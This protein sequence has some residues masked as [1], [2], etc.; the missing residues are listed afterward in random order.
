MTE[1]QVLEDVCRRLEQAGIAY[2]L[3]GSMAMSYYA[4]PRMTR[5]IDLVVAVEPDQA[6]KLASAFEPDYYVPREQLEESIRAHGMFNL[7]HLESVVKVDLIVR[8]DEP[9][10]RTEFDRRRRV[11]LPGFEAWIASKEDLVL[12]KLVWAREGES[13]V[14]RRDVRNLLDSGA[15]L[16]YLRQWAPRLGVSQLLEALLDEGHHP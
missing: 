1:L 3:T 9:Y 13:E 15:D 12:S 14:Q 5:D 6:D 10:R 8:K 16:E 7:L 2:M 11:A 4:Q